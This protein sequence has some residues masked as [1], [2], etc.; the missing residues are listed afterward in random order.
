MCDFLSRGL[1]CFGEEAGEV[2]VGDVLEEGAAGDVLEEFFDPAE[3]VLPPLGLEAA[4]GEAGE[5]FLDEVGFAFGGGGVEV[6]AVL[7]AVVEGGEFLEGA[8]AEFLGFLGGE[9]GVLELGEELV[10]EAEP[11]GGVVGEEG[12]EAAMADDFAVDAAYFGAED[13]EGAAAGIGVGVVEGFDVLAAGLGFA[14]LGADGGVGDVIGAG[15]D[16]D[17]DDGSA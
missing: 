11:A 13:D 9:G 6:L 2:G 14:D 12:G 16:G 17:A 15:E 10:D 7:G 4:F 1:P 8:V 5:V 3:S